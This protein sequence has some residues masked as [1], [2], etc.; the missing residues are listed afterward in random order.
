MNNETC[1]KLAISV[2]LV[3]LTITMYQYFYLNASD[4]FQGNL[5]MENLAELEEVDETEMK[6]NIDIKTPV[7][8]CKNL[9]PEYLDDTSIH[10][11]TVDGYLIRNFDDKKNFQ[12]E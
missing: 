8:M 7:N 12:L 6:S 5:E 10:G 2:I 11:Y 4:N 9:L 3:L 1:Y